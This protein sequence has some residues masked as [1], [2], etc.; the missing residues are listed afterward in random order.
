MRNKNINF[1]I[2]SL[3][4]TDDLYNKLDRSL[5]NKLFYYNSDFRSYRFQ[6]LHIL[7]KLDNLNHEYE[8]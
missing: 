6:I 2:C 4:F 3:F 5:K 7:D 1:K 8:E